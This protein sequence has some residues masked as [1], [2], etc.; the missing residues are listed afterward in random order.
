MEDEKLVG[1]GTDSGRVIG[2]MVQR[3]VVRV[4]TSSQV[5]FGAAAD[6]K[7]PVRGKY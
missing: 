3:P 7:K 5:N 6:G 1:V 4:L 2:D